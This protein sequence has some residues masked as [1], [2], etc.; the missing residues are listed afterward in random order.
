M[1]P[2]I[3]RQGFGLAAVASSAAAVI[4]ASS[5]VSPAIAEDDVTVV[6]DC[7]GF[8]AAMQASGTVVLGDSIGGFEVEC[9]PVDLAA[10]VDIILDL[11]DHEIYV[12]DTVEPIDGAGVFVPSDSRLVIRGEYHPFGSGLASG[13]IV[14]GGGTGAG[15]GAEPGS[16]PSGPI[17]IEGGAVEGVSFG[18]A[19]I[20]G[21]DGDAHVTIRGGLVRG[22][23]AIAA[24]DD[25]TG[26]GIGGGR[27]GTGVVEITG[28]I[29]TG[30]AWTAAGIG[31]GTHGDGDVT[32]TIPDAAVPAPDQH[33]VF[34]L[35]FAGAGIGGGIGGTGLL[36]LA[37]GRI[38][39]SVYP[40]P[41]ATGVGFGDVDGTGHVA[42]GGHSEVLVQ[43][44]RSGGI[45]ITGGS[46]E[47]IDGFAAV[48]PRPTDGSRELS[49]ISATVRVDGA[50]PSPGPLVS[51]PA[52]GGTPSAYE[53]L[54]PSGTATLWLPPGPAKL[55]ATVGSQGRVF[56]VDVAP[57]G[58]SAVFLDFT[59]ATPTLR[60]R[61]IARF[62]QLA[63]T[64]EYSDR[65]VR[66]IAREF[67]VPESTVRLWL[68]RAGALG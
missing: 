49:P 37:G 19:G 34:G 21:A 61:V 36:D 66:V 1:H 55:A 50:V 68:R 57:D 29:T 63:R 65:A 32:V 4:A 53:T 31:G 44:I 62:A 28:G 17:V 9:P 13:R 46:V 43:S 6:T 56:P 16:G 8:A 60:E 39:A 59:S 11:Q 2:P 35:S 52:A 54:T 15:I 24:R 25:E 41:A 40:D 5:P 48:E 26:A 45:D 27:T 58:T 12:G 23:V 10:G 67:G 18:A 7:V 47:V 51:V 42:I 30:V 3:R 20:G 14:A 38:Q 22:Q 33:N 64:I